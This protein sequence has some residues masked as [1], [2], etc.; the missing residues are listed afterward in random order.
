MT[1]PTYAVLGAGR[2]GLAAAL[3]FALHG[4]AGRILLGD[5][6]SAVAEAA[7]LRLDE[8]A[9]RSVAEPLELDGA[10]AASLA[11]IL[12]PAD[13]ALSGL[14]YALN[15]GAAAAACRARTNFVDLGGNSAISAEVLALDEEAR[16]AGVTL[17]PDCGLAPGL[18][19]TLTA[20]LFEAFDEPESVHLR[21]GGLP[22]EPR[23]PLDYQLVFSM[24][25]LTNEYLGE[26][27]LLRD[28]AVVSV[29]TLTEL[30][31][32]EFSEPVGACE[33][34][35][36]SGGTSTLPVSYLG[37]LANLDYKTV[38]YPGHC[39]KIAAM[40]DLGLLSDDPVDVPGGRVRPRDVFHAVAAPA[41]DLPG[42]DLIVLRAEVSGIHEGRLRRRRLDVLDFQDETTGLTAMQRMTGFPAAMVLEALAR[43]EAEPGATPLEFVLPAAPLVA[44]L[45]ARGIGVEDVELEA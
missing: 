22:R 27:E 45:G 8:L 36:T 33:A 35:T 19:A 1:A 16:A 12:E 7:A 43:G 31:E 44:G 20:F 4:E 21:C 3:D 24:G 23:G 6:D 11:R 30:E 39:A 13:A 29:P 25:G 14:P 34:F 10:D 9:G 5:R 26:A 41:L 15:P 32:L 28:G 38:R 42:R 37:K 40:R 18:T 17:V 2:Q